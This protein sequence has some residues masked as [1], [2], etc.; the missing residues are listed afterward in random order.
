MS[1]LKPITCPDMSDADN[2]Y[3]DDVDAIREAE[4]PMLHGWS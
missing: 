1:P 2:V 4:Y 3:G